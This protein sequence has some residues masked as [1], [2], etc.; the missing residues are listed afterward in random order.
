MEENCAEKTLAMELD[1][2]VLD[3]L[4]F[5]ATGY[6]LENHEHQ[7][8]DDHTIHDAGKMTLLVQMV[9]CQ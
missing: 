7:M 8:E 4:A 6:A 9:D 3:Y 5:T 1:M 2:M